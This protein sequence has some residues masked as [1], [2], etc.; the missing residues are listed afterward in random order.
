MVGDKERVIKG[1]RVLVLENNTGTVVM[2]GFNG[3][4]IKLL[5][6]TILLRRC[7][8]QLHLDISHGFQLAPTWPLSHGCVTLCLHT[9]T[10]CH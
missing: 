6:T 8:N 10:P 1:G 5:L 7:L 4:G 2:H 3:P 9:E